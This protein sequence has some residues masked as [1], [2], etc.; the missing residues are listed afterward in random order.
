MCSTVTGFAPATTGGTS[1]FTCPPAPAP[2]AIVSPS[3]TT[4][5]QYAFFMGPFVLQFMGIKPSHPLYFRKRLLGNVFLGPTREDFSQNSL[6]FVP[7]GNVYSHPD[8]NHPA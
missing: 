1:V 3:T 4:P 2:D 7:V 6:T 5:N 8:E